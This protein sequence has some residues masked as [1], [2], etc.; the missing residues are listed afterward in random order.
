MTLRGHYAL[1]QEL[2][3]KLWRVFPS[4]SWAFLF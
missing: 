4:D 3:Y 2:L 1:E